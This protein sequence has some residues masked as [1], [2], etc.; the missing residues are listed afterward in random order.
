LGLLQAFSAI[1]LSGCAYRPSE[2]LE[3][4]ISIACVTWR[5]AS[6]KCDSESDSTIKES[7]SA[8]G[9]KRTKKR[10]SK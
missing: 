1:K 2:T 6:K 4:A 8:R 5:S 9:T 3:S 7:Q 10:K